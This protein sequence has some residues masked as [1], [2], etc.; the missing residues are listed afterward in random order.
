MPCE[1]LRRAVARASPAPA[2]ESESEAGAPSK[3]LLT[4]SILLLLLVAALLLP[5]V[6]SR[7]PMPMPAA[8]ADLT[9]A[10]VRWPMGKDARLSCAWLSRD[11]KYVYMHA[12]IDEGNV[13]K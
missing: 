12:W 4:L 1:S 9:S 8:A 3:L 13:H 6:A 11:R 5:G 10:L 2:P 7:R